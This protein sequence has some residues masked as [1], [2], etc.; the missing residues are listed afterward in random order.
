MGLEFFFCR[1]EKSIEDLAKLAKFDLKA[2]KL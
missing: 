1:G 2:V